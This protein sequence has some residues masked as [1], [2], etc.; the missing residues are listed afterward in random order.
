MKANSLFLVLND[1]YWVDYVRAEHSC[2]ILATI[3][4]IWYSFVICFSLSMKDGYRLVRDCIS[5]YI[6]DSCPVDFTSDLGTRFI[7]HPTVLKMSQPPRIVSWIAHGIAS[8]LDALFLSKFEQ[9]RAHYWQTLYSSVVSNRVY[10][11]YSAK[12]SLSTHAPYIFPVLTIHLMQRM[13]A[14]YL[15]LCSE[16]DDL[17]SY[18]VIC[19]FA[20]QLQELG[21]DIKVVTWNDSPH[22]GRL[23]NLFFLDYYC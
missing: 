14:P 21:G 9:Q 5:G 18:Q 2:V 16:D 4:I 1:S 12:V 7:L 6:Y 13:K 11:Q 22:V 19:N 20:Q 10:F 17:A 8:S 23:L 15:I 3:H